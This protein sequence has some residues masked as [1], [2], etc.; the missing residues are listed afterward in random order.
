MTRW[1]LLR[2]LSAKASPRRLLLLQIANILAF[3][4]VLLVNGFSSVGVIGKAIFNVSHMY[5]SLLSASPSTF[6]ICG[7]LILLEG[8]FHLYMLFLCLQGAA[9]RWLPLLS[10]MWLTKC[11]LTT[12]WPSV[13]AAGWL[14]LSFAILVLILLIASGTHLALYRSVDL[15]YWSTA[16]R[17]TGDPSAPAAGKG[18]A[19]DTIE[20]R[21]AVLSRLVSSGTGTGTGT[22]A[23][24]MRCAI[25]PWFGFVLRGFVVKLWA[26]VY[27]GC[28]L[29]AMLANLALVLKYVVC[30]F[31]LPITAG[32]TSPILTH[33]AERFGNFTLTS[34]YLP[35]G[36]CCALPPLEPASLINT[37]GMPP[38]ATIDEAFVSAILLVAGAVVSFVVGNMLDDFVVPATMSWWAW[39]V[40]R[41]ARTLARLARISGA[42]AD[43]LCAY[44]ITALVAAITVA[45]TAIAAIAL[46]ARLVL[47]P[48]SGTRCGGTSCTASCSCSEPCP[49]PCKCGTGS[50]AGQWQADS[51]TKQQALPQGQPQPQTQTPAQGVG[52]ERQSDAGRDATGTTAGTGGTTTA[53]GVGTSG[54]GIGGGGITGGGGGGMTGM[55]GGV[56]PGMTGGGMTT[57]GGVTAAGGRGGMQTGGGGG[58]HS[59]G[60]APPAVGVPVSSL[61]GVPGGGTLSGR[62]TSIPR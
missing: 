54:S 30:R 24:D 5:P 34:S 48:R 32:A 20:Q 16:P 60:G 53:G 42:A 56:V 51:A 31:N 14:T 3:I 4:F 52:Q 46:A 22:V 25:G 45:L 11:A 18:V 28:A 39:G 26:S 40:H 44:E 57:A 47:C 17:E 12:V 36:A 29:F 7:F 49:T 33:A 2:C 55:A 43:A 27:V 41:Q 62:G 1:N 8:L 58:G 13:F 23:S 15:R 59:L 35:F 50:D 21:R 10:L 38:S 37:T 9:P 19:S 61:T 6:G